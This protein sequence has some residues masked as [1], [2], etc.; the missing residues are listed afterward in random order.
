MQSKALKHILKFVVFSSLLVFF[1]LFYFLDQTKQYLNGSSTFALRNEDVT[2]FDIPVHVLCMDPIYSKATKWGKRNITITSL[3]MKD[4]NKN[5]S[6]IQ[7]FEETSY[8]LGQDFEIEFANTLLHHGKSEVE[9]FQVIV[10]YLDTFNHGRC[11]MVQTY[12]K[13][14]PTSEFFFKVRTKT[15]KDV[16]KPKSLKLFLVSNQTWQGIGTDVW[17]YIK[18]TKL[19]LPFIKEETYW[20]DLHV[21]QYIYQKGQKD[22]TSCISKLVTNSGCLPVCSPFFFP[23][24]LNIEPCQTFGDTKC[25]FDLYGESKAFFFSYKKCLK[26]LT[27]FTYTGTPILLEGQDISDI[28][29]DLSVYGSF[30]FSSNEIQIYEETTIIGTSTFIGSVGGSLGLFLGFSCFTCLSSCLDYFFDFIISLKSKVQN[31]NI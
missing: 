26:P 2:E 20:T 6:L 5:E 17:S 24:N 9:N 11:L 1:I 7:F 10:Q 8:H 28:P 3:L 18:P 31:N 19:I 21:K 30:S 29:K 16:G 4:D 25:L 14:E 12:T 13:L 22:I 15:R 23:P 27:I